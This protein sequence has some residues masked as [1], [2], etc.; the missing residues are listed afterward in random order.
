VQIVTLTWQQT[1]P[2]RH[3][4]LWPSEPPEYCKVEGDETALHVGVMIEG[5]LVC[6]ASVYSEVASNAARLRK[7]ATLP[8]YQ[9]KGIGT[10][11]IHHLIDELTKQGII[12]F[13]FDA[14][15]SALSFYQRLG[16]QTSSELFYKNK[17]PFYKMHQNLVVKSKLNSPI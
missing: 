6:V 8:A 7:F 4:V 15:A 16:F 1:L 5:E 11:L 17:V 3:Q 13:W 10:H 14:R 12:Y 2:I 9:G